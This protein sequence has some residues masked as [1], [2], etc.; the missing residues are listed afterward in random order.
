MAP[1]APGGGH[2]ASFNLVG[3][4]FDFL[5]DA[6]EVLSDVIVPETE[7][8]HT[9]RA[10]PLRSTLVPKLILLFP[11]LAA[12]EFYRELQRWAVEVENIRPSRMLA[13]KA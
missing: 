8:S 13:A 12:V 2:T 11:V 9:A 6:A 7:F 4:C 10:Q 1:C 3:C 5:K